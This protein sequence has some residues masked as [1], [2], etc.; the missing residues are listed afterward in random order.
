MEEK[1]GEEEVLKA[2]M[3][4]IGLFK[5]WYICIYILPSNKLLRLTT[6]P[7]KPTWNVAD[8]WRLTFSKQ[9]SCTEK[10]NKAEKK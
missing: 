8:K 7:L 1:S 5:I 9:L 10:K 3:M 2:P 4:H 6:K